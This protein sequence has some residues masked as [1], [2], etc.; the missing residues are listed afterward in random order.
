MEQLFL[1]IDTDMSGTISLKE[2]VDH[3]LDSFQ[4][5]EF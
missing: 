3:Y 2:F 5:L 4:S 1:Q